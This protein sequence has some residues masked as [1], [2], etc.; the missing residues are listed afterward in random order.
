M[1]SRM[2]RFPPKNLCNFLM[3]WS[4]CCV[5]H[6]QAKWAVGLVKNRHPFYNAIARECGDAAVPICRFLKIL[7]GRV[8]TAQCTHLV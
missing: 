6:Q 1:G 4:E 3:E 5:W 7:L 8:L 2:A